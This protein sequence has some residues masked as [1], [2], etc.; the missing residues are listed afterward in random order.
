ME[1]C[2]LPSLPESALYGTKIADEFFQVN[3]GG[4]SVFL[5][6][7]LRHLLERKLEDR[8]LIKAHTE[9]F[10]ESEELLHTLEWAD[11]EWMGLFQ[12]GSALRLGLASGPV[13]R[14]HPAGKAVHQHGPRAKR[15]HHRGLERL[16]PDEQ[17]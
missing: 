8:A 14:D 9:G 4:D 7:P 6:E 11:L 5:S 13:P 2:W 16:H 15:R 10:P 1:R 17:I 12:C 3:I